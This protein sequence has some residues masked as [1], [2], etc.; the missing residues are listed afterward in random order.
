MQ[1]GG[2][3]VVLR[4]DAVVRTAVTAGTAA[5][6]VGRARGGHACVSDSYDGCAR[7][8]AVKAMGGPATATPGR[9]LLFF[10]S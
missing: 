8:C 3:G 1:P 2:A 9:G 5:M 7:C 6:G 4:A 10:G